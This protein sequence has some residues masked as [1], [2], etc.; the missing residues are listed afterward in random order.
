MHLIECQCRTT[1][2]LVLVVACGHYL[3][4][5][6]ARSVTVSQASLVHNKA[7]IATVRC[8]NDTD[9]YATRQ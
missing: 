4:L 6:E 8:D 1:L 5:P 2:W 3:V 7:T 9:V